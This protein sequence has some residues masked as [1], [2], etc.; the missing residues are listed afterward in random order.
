MFVLFELLKYT[1]Q[2]DYTAVDVDEKKYVD[3]Y[4]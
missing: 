3:F 1:G 4:F 2:S